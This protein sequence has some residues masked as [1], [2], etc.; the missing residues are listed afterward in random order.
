MQ[1]KLSNFILLNLE[2]N[3]CVLGNIQCFKG[4][5]IFIIM[6]FVPNNFQIIKYYLYGIIKKKKKN[7]DYF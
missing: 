6:H 1:F 3:T 5:Q 2:N 4:S 7:L